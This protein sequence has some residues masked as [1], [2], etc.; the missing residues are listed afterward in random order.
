MLSFFLLAALA[1]AQEPATV[2]L[3]PNGAPG[4]LGAEDSDQPSLTIF[5]PVKNQ[6][7]GTGVIVC[8]GGSY[9]SLASNQ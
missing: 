9:I 8:P 2:L 4:A 7:N 1:C 5:L 6:A 3:W